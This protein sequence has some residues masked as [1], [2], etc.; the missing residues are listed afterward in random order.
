MMTREEK[1]MEQRKLTIAD[2]L[3]QSNLLRICKLWTEQNYQ[4][5]QLVVDTA[6]RLSEKV[7]TEDDKLM[8]YVDLS[9]GRV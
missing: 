9:A 5:Y 3:H 2:I 8:V 4:N 6:E 1:N 7:I